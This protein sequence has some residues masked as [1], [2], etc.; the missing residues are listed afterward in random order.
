MKRAPFDNSLL[1]D[2]KVGRT[3]LLSLVVGTHVIGN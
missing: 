1:S 2:N 3:H